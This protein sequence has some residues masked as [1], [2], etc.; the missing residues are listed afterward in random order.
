[1]KW[2]DIELAARAVSVAVLIVAV[3]YLT[4]AVLGSGA[5]LALNITIFLAVV[6]YLILLL[7]RANM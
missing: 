7:V 6:I 1:M 3:E 5:L 2:F 4:G